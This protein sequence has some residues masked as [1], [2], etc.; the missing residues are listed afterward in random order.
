MRNILRQVLVAVSFVQILS[1]SVSAEISGHVYD[2]DHHPVSA[3]T[4]TFAPESLSDGTMSAVTDSEGYYSIDVET[5]VKND[6]VQ[7]PSGVKLLQ[8]FPNP[9]NPS[10]TIPFVLGTSGYA[11]LTVYDILGRRVQ[12]LAIG[13]MKEGSHTVTWD[14][15]DDYGIACAAGVY[16][17][18]LISNGRSEVNKMLLV[19]GGSN[20]AAVMW[21]TE[22][23]KLSNSTETSV[24]AVTI[25]GDTIEHFEKTAFKPPQNGENSDF[26]V[27][28]SDTGY[29][30]SLLHVND[31]HAQL[32]PVN[33]LGMTLD[34]DEAESI[35]GFPRLATQSSFLRS[36]RQNSLFLFGGDMFD[37]EGMNDE[38]LDTLLP[39]VNM[40]SF[41]AVTLG[42]H[43]FNSGEALFEK[44]LSGLTCPVVSSN[45]S[46]NKDSDMHTLILNNLIIERKGRRIGI[47]GCTTDAFDYGMYGIQNIAFNDILESVEM[48]VVDLQDEGIDIIILLS[49]LGYLDD[50]LLAAAI[51]DIDVIVGGHSHALFSNTD[52]SARLPYPMLVNSPTD[53]P[54]LVVQSGSLTRYLG[55][56]DILFDDNGVALHWAGDSRMLDS[57]VEHY[58]PMR[59]LIESH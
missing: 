2:I 49:H 57:A 19:D 52:E 33:S 18:R 47:V 26:L 16:L 8:N 14:G 59:S 20:P 28:R 15:T 31:L 38:Q 22:S 13:Y 30:L 11:E 50:L 36:Q 56:L 41:D 40:L 5:S 12:T 9:F 7:R 24:Y 29:L 46:I 42:N 17:Y 6:A 4:V 25:N 48:A 35:G 10:T 53:E 45:I 43:D 54:V 51:E 37:R 55:C 3:A 23:P 27:T 1:V 44:Y 58:E 34:F 32:Y 39:Y 21:L